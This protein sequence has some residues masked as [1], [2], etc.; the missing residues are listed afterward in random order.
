MEDHLLLNENA[1][2]FKKPEGFSLSKSRVKQ[3]FSHISKKT[4]REGNYL[5]NE[6]Y[7]DY[8]VDG[9]Q[10]HYSICVFK[11]ESVP[12]FID[13]YIPGWIE[14]KLAYLILVEFENYIVVTK[15][16]ISGMAD[17]FK[18]LDP[19]DYEILSTL[20]IED[21]TMFEKF[22][23]KNMSISDKAIRSKTMESNDLKE[24]FS[25]IG[26]GN[27]IVDNMRLKTGS[28]KVALSLNTSRINKFGSKN[29]LDAFFGWSKAVI[30][31]VESYVPQNTFLNVFAQPISFER[32]K[33]TLVPIAILFL[34]NKLYEDF[35]SH[36]I[37]GCLIVNDAGERSINIF[38]YLSEFERLL[39]VAPR[40]DDDGGVCYIAQ[41]SLTDDLEIRI[42]AKSITIY[43]RKL[44]NV[45]L[46]TETGH[47]RSITEYINTSNQFIVNFDQL[48][49]VYTNRKLFLDNR[50]LG[51]INY[52][53]D[54][55]VPY[56]AL[57]N[58]NSEK[59][60]FLPTATEFTTQS[61][62]RFVED[63]FID[64]FDFFLCDDL[65]K[66]WADHIGITPDK[67]TFL[68]SKYKETGYSASSFQD[69][70][71]QALKNIT[72]LT[73]RD[74]QLDSKRVI[75][76]NHYIASDGTSTQIT[77]LRKGDTVNDF[78]N[79]FSE[80]IKNPNLNREIFLVINFISKTGLQQKL[81]DLRDGL[82]FPER[83]EVIQILWFLSSFLSI[84]GEQGIKGYICCKP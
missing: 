55:F 18:L 80:T 78:I 42:N 77:R 12:S 25:T 45:K 29:Y 24:N 14:T 37:T 52:F 81:E 32:E 51:N 44:Q 5:L 49:L 43:S 63:T 6:P 64:D 38:D 8:V 41:T 56:P 39:Q 71:G 40:T 2:I 19:L 79:Q 69:V 82:A 83:N 10:I 33:D 68:H 46:V 60:S 3:L 48:E 53:L 62:F 57:I 54:A 74:Y 67:I 28:E 72:N 75:W 58:V 47:L 26:A 31:R 1:Y 61:E 70:V 7:L 15:K 34:F 23:L 16:N 11:F 9:T 35:E 20:F 4:E 84:C 76:G 73:P 59:G 22:G 17:F 36:R 27:Y 21:S 65:G 13:E 66:E 30:D 50:L